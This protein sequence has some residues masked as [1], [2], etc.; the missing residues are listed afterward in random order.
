MVGALREVLVDALLRKPVAFG[1]STIN[2][3]R[4][5]VMVWSRNVVAGE[6]AQPL[7]M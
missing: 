5:F 7:P 6:R 2:S 3:P 4:R 1:C